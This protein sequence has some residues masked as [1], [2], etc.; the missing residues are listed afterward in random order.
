MIDFIPK[1]PQARSDMLGFLP[2][3]WDESDPRSARDQANN[4]YGHGG[5]WNPF[6]GFRMTEKGIAYPGDPIMP[7]LFEAK[8]RDETI[9]V[10][11]CAWV[12]I[13]QKDGS[14]EICRMD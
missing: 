14:Y 10:Y 7:L 3:F 11:D 8:L 2:A 9:R 1:H 4:A 6:N 13:V 12:A 5:G